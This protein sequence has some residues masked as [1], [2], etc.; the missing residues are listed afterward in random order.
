MSRRFKGCQLYSISL[1][2]HSAFTCEYFA[3]DEWLCYWIS[4]H[5]AST[6]NVHY[7][8][9]NSIRHGALG[10]DCIGKIYMWSTFPLSNRWYMHIMYTCISIY[11]YRYVFNSEQ[12][13]YNLTTNDMIYL[14]VPSWHPVP[15]YWKEFDEILRHITCHVC[16]ASVQQDAYRWIRIHN[17]KQWIGQLNRIRI[18]SLK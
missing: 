14:E 2:K 9:S 6:D 8:K 5:L 10:I 1:C 17:S 4:I 16:G 11:V 3:M 15:Q 13:V 18:S 12:Y 7:W